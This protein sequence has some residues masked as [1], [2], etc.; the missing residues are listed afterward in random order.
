M[1]MDIAKEHVS[2]LASQLE[3][4]AVTYHTLS[5]D[6]KV[7]VTSSKQMLLEY[8]R[9]NKTRV[10]ASFLATGSRDGANKVELFADEALLQDACAKLFDII[11]T[12]HVYSL[13]LAKNNA[14][15]QELA[16]QE[17]RRPV[18]LGD[19]ALYYNL[20]VIEGPPLRA[21]LKNASKPEPAR[22]SA[23]ERARATAAPVK[24]TPKVKPVTEKP[25]LVYQLRKQQPKTT[26]LSNYV[27]RKGEST[28]RVAEKPT[29]KPAYQYKSRKTE[30][31]MPKERVVMSVDN[32]EETES[33]EVDEPAPAAKSAGVD[34]NS[35]FVD[36]FT[37]EDE[38]EP[39]K[40]QPIMVE[41]PEPEPENVEAVSEENA[42]SESP[43]PSILD[44]LPT[45]SGSEAA[46]AKESPPPETT[47]DDDG[48]FTLYKK[49][50]KSEPKNQPKD[51]PK[52]AA[53]AEPNGSRLSKQAPKANKKNTGK[54][55][56]SV[57]S[58]FGKR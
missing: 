16:L 25:K 48:Y 30:Q 44:S 31:T 54:K 7:H 21:T 23:P 15:T 56:A 2:Y 46:S 13:Q 58:F 39:E 18:D 33:M 34:L 40:D 26:L 22:A 12:V 57:M 51:E 41:H 8:Y 43:G 55:Q 24:D 3:T 17:L 28:K 36:D 19:A 50:S 6:L 53:K 52:T 49:E 9:A 1:T 11:H 5:R 20:G 45:R 14:S 29:D 37:D 35:L 38:S 32:D 4:N 10:A 47:I 42:H 27:S